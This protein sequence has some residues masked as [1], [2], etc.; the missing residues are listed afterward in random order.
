MNQQ[1]A[2]FLL[3]GYPIL[4][5]IIYALLCSFWRAL[6][7]TAREGDTRRFPRYGNPNE[8]VRPFRKHPDML[9]DDTDLHKKE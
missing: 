8:R 5:A 3:C 9:T 7:I 1:E 4:I 2:I 6:E